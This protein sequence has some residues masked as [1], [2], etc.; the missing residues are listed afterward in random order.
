MWMS[1]QHF[2]QPF[3]LWGILLRI[4]SNVKNWAHSD[5]Y[6][7][8]Y[9]PI[10]CKFNQNQTN[11]SGLPLFL[12]MRIIFYYTCTHRIL[13]KILGVFYWHFYTPLKIPARL[14]NDEIFLF[15][16]ILIKS[17]IVALRRNWEK[18]REI[19]KNYEEV[20]TDD[21]EEFN[22]EQEIQEEKIM[23]VL[24]HHEEDQS[25]VYQDPVL[26][27]GMDPLELRPLL[28]RHATEGLKNPGTGARV[29][30]RSCQQLL[31]SRTSFE[32]YVIFKFFRSSSGLLQLT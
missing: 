24:F 5:F 26:Q 30:C 11:T 16:P 2:T 13:N 32:F 4:E 3:V 31:V 20:G 25:E 29:K 23:R 22:E 7:R 17:R 15:P 18:Y 19:W 9:L 8:N 27:G 10:S 1:Y 14:D 21:I 6:F 12:E 28:L